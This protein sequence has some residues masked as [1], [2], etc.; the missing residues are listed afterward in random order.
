AARADG[1]GYVISGEKTW[2][3]NAGIADHYVVFCR[4]PEL[5]ERAFGAFMVDAD[6]PGLT[7]SERI[8]VMAP[9][10]LGTLRFEGCRVGAD[11]LVG[12]PGKGLRVALGTLDVFRTSVGAAALGMARRA[13]AEALAQDRKSTRL[14]SSHV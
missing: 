2:I 11:A 13:L 10:P 4:M 3:S 5:G 8:D 7:V 6:A 9:Q 1:D 12:E 14:N